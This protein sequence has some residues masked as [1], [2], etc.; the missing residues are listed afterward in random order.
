MTKCIFW[1]KASGGDLEERSK[2]VIETYKFKFEEVLP[3][4]QSFLL[5][6]LFMPQVVHGRVQKVRSNFIKIRRAFFTP[7]PCLLMYYDLRFSWPLWTQRS[8]IRLQQSLSLIRAI[9]KAKGNLGRSKKKAAA[10]VEK[11][12]LFSSATKMKYI[13]VKG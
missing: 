7:R 13:M 11:F 9:R 2:Q 12:P 10:A 4:R 1:P 6:T 3:V 8:L 5:R